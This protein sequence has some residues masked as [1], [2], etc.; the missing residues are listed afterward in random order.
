[1]NLPKLLTD[2]LVAEVPADGRHQIALGHD[3]AQTLITD[4][5]VVYV[6]ISEIA[7]TVSESNVDGTD[8]ARLSMLVRMSERNIPYL[9]RGT[10]RSIADWTVNDA[11]VFRDE[12]Q[13][14]M[15]EIAKDLVDE[16]RGFD[17]MVGDER[18]TRRG[19]DFV[20]CVSRGE[21][22]WTYRSRCDP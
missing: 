4:S 16:M 1:V 10:S 3:F 9:Y 5:R 22:R 6:H 7:L 2:A 20:N 21:R 14:G 13:A 18:P 17:R 12:L 11:Q 15:R 8:L 19:E